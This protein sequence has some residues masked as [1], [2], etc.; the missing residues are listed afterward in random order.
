M[1][2]N[3]EKCFQ[4]AATAALTRTSLGLFEI[5]K[6]GGRGEGGGSTS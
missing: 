3:D 2:K 5:N 1:N 6:L 4:Y